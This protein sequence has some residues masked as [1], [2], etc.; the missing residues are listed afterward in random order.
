VEDRL[1]AHDQVDNWG[2]GNAVALD[3]NRVIVGAS[4]AD[5]NGETN[6]GAAYV[7]VRQGDEWVEEA[8]LLAFDGAEGDFF[9][10]SVAPS[11]GVWELK[12]KNR[13]QMDWHFT[14]YRFEIRLHHEGAPPCVT[15][16]DP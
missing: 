10:T 5:I 16:P 3:G 6:R 13:M 8:E 7:F 11:P 1:F 14:F 4:R 2:F 15:N 12:L 9:G